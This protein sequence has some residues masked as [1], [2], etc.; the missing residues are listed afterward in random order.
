M[1]DQ[2]AWAFAN[3][4]TQTLTLAQDLPPERAC[5]QSTPGK[6][7]ATWILGHL[8]LGDTYLLTL[9]GLEPLAQ[10]FR[11]FSPGTARERHPS[12]RESSTIPPRR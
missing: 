2:L 6:H 3:A 7:H 11:R 12:R 1:K 5:L 4:R 8:L 10:T 9:L